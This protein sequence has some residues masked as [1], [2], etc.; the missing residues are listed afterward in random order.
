[1]A[2][3]NSDGSRSL[4]GGSSEGLKSLIPDIVASRPVVIA[5]AGGPTTRTLIDSN[6]QLPI[7]FTVSADAMISRLVDSWARPEAC[8]RIPSF[9]SWA[10]F[11]EAGNLMTHGP[12]LRECYARIASFGG[13]CH[14]PRR[15]AKLTDWASS[16]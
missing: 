16:R 8:R 13:L 12:V 15:S 4:G 11:A 2:C 1:M 5:A 14:P 3:G 6:V 7:A 9:S 10:V